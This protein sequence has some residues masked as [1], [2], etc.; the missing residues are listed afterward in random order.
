MTQTITTINQHYLN[1]PYSEFHQEHRLGGS[2]KVQMIMAEQDA[3]DLWDPAV[4]QVMFVGTLKASARAE[5][6]FGNGNKMYSLPI[7]PVDF[8]L[9]DRITS[10]WP[11]F[12]P[13]S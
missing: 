7:R 13:A 4:S 6:D 12:L 9:Q 8:A 2:F 10:W 5:L 3:I 11:L 1:S